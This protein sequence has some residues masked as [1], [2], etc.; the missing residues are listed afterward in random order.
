MTEGYV[1]CVQRYAG[2]VGRYY[3][4]TD[5]QHSATGSEAHKRRAPEKTERRAPT[6]SKHGAQGSLLWSLVPRQDAG[7]RLTTPVLRSSVSTVKFVLLYY[8]IRNIVLY[9]VSN[10]AKSKRKEKDMYNNI[11]QIWKYY[12]ALCCGKLFLFINY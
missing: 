3:S 10:L 11:M 4:G 12:L 6:G 8:S 5:L 9:K 7:F 2:W 1:L